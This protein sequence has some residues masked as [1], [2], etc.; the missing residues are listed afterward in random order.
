[1]PTPSK[2]FIDPT[3]LST[4]AA[5]VPLAA[6]V[7]LDATVLAFP[8]PPMP[9]LTP[10]DEQIPYITTKAQYVECE[11]HTPKVPDP[12]FGRS[13]VTTFPAIYKEKQTP[14]GQLWPIKL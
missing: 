1:M 11:S 14:V 2:A 9:R 12:P 3:Y 7:R 6:S 5:R 4:K 13:I 10:P 8:I